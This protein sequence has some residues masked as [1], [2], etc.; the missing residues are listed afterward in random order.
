MFCTQC[1]RELPKDGKPCVCGSGQAEL[2]V[3]NRTEEQEWA[4]DETVLPTEMTAAEPET[5]ALEEAESAAETELQQEE[6]VEPEE[7][8]WNEPE[9]VAQEYIP[10][11]NE[12]MN[13]QPEPYAA[14]VYAVQQENPVIATIRRVAGSPLF[15]IA[16]IV[17]SLHFVLNIVN[18]WMPID[19]IGMVNNLV[20]YFDAVIPGIGA[21][22]M[23]DI[24][25]ALTEIKA[26]QAS[27]SL[28]SMLGMIM[29][30]LTVAALW[31]TYGSAKRADGPKTAGLTMLQVL[32]ILAVIG[33]S[34][35]ILLSVA[36]GGL[37]IVSVQ[38]LLNQLVYYGV[39]ANELS[40]GIT[41]GVVVL[42]VLLL[43]ASVF[44]LIYTAK[45]LST[46]VGVKR[47][48]RTGMVMK[49]ASGFVAVVNLLIAAWLV[50]DLYGTFVL[51]GWMAALVN[52]FAAAAYVLFAV[53][54]FNYNKALKPLRVPKNAVGYIPKQ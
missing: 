16:A 20:G 11:V 18:R 32:Q 25:P 45:V 38:A 24:E 39:I 28:I 40:A 27:L 26:A 46:V 51:L 12:Q 41:V 49:K 4:V 36:L 53:C 34:F 30:A 52:F 13:M 19:L 3:Q 10:P 47:A 17:V 29:P 15:L 8:A 9:S 50:F 14:P 35:M 1:G 5:V 23:K 7:T 48:I 42:A 54:I 43:V 37:L 6:N 2:V 22:M 31:M 21:Q 44:S 33:M